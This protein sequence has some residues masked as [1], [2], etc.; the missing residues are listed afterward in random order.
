GVDDAA[1]VD[2]AH[3]VERL[4]ARV[5]VE[6][7]DVDALVEAGEAPAGR[8]PARLADVP[9]RPALPRPLLLAAEVALEAHVEPRRLEVQ[10]GLVVGGEE[11]RDAGGLLAVPTTGLRTSGPGRARD[12]RGSEQQEGSSGYGSRHGSRGARGGRRRTGRSG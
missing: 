4:A 5:A 9:V 7:R 12:H 8:R 1:L 3:L 2:G 11:E 6:R 10:D